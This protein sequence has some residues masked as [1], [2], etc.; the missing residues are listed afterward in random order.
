MAE[1]LYLIHF[2]RGE[3]YCPLCFGSIV[4]RKVGTRK[5][6]PC[7]RAPVLCTFDR[8]PGLR[9]V[10]NGEIIQGVKILTPQNAREFVGAR[11]FYALQPHIFTCSELQRLRKRGMSN[12]QQSGSDGSAHG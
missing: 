10:K 7:D 6:C 12:A 1:R 2:N 9:V 3:E 4:W 8:F 5:Y 11:T